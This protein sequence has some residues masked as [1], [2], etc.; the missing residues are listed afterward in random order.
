ML[1]V[2]PKGFLLICQEYHYV[3]IY[4]EEHDMR[5]YALNFL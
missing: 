2:V 3:F 1:L 5:T 4:G